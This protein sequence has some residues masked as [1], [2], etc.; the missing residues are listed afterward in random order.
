V[1][2][3][4]FLCGKDWPEDSDGIWWRFGDE[5]SAHCTDFD[6]CT[7]RQIEQEEASDGVQ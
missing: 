6:A 1:T 4:C 2:V 7:T 3:T 5:D